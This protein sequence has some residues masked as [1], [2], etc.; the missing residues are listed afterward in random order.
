MSSQVSILART[1]GIAIAAVVSA[2][3]GAMP[4]ASQAA[5]AHA[6]G[7][8]AR[9]QATLTRAAGAT[10]PGRHLPRE[11]ARLTSP[12]RPRARFRAAAAP[13][14]AFTLGTPPAQCQVGGVG[15]AFKS[16][17]VSGPRVYGAD[18]ATTVYWRA[19]AWR[20]GATRVEVQGQWHTAR[21]TT[22]QR[23]V[24]AADHLDFYDFNLAMQIWHA[25]VQVYR[26]SP[27]RGWESA[28]AANL[29]I[30]HKGA[31]PLPDRYTSGC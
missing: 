29:P 11:L 12:T 16:L 7:P 24:F 30:L 1:R 25:G 10:A 18:N 2:S 6:A 5:P 15:R 9:A 4:A 23:A 28:S 21:A 22:S 27:S 19:V 26:S 17:W 3:I 20:D 14:F 13:A 31:Y 8:A